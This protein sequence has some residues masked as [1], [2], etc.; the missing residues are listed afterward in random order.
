M[1]QPSDHSKFIFS[2][3]V[4]YE[5]TFNPDDKHQFPDKKD[6]RTNNV[7]SCFE[8]ITNSL[9][10]DTL[11]HLFPEVSM[12]QYGNATKNRYARVH[13]HG[14]ILFKTTESLTSFLLK[15]WHRFTSI[16]SIQFNPYRPDHWDTYCRKQKDLFHRRYR[17]KNASWD[18]IKSLAALSP[19]EKETALEEGFD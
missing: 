12:P 19:E 13:Y 11:Y 18:S 16:S 6:A 10:P 3:G 15:H 4:I 1:S 14:I 9:H 2:K 7:K 5:F 8:E 17:I